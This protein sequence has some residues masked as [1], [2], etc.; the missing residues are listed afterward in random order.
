MVASDVSDSAQHSVTFYVHCTWDEVVGYCRAFH[1][2]F[3]KIIALAIT[4]EYN[5]L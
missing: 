3:Y 4:T 5:T 1:L 2:Q